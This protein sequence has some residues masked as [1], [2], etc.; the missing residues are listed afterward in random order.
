MSAMNQLP[1]SNV[2]DPAADIDLEASL[3]YLLNR[4]G[5]RIGAA[6]S[7]DIQR[8]GI[9][10]HQ[11]RVLA[12]LSH[13]APQ[14]ITELAAHTS[15]EVSTLSRIAAALVGDGL[16]ARLRSGEDARSVGL[17]LTAKGREIAGRISPVAALYERIALSGMDAGEVALLKQLLAKVYDNLISLGPRVPA[18][19]KGVGRRAVTAAGATDKKPGDLRP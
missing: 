9:S 10:L 4:A 3:P 17:T 5:V 7:E 2:P 6:F 12:S 13:Q 16:L 1:E 15:I 18:R 8:S 11:W 14:N 19:R